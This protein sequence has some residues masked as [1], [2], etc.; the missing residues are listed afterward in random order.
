[1]KKQNSELTKA[2]L[3]EWG[4]YSIEWDEEQKTWVIDRF[5][6]KNKSRSK[7]HTNIK[8]CKAVCKHKYTKDKYYP[9][10]TFSYMNSIKSIPLA[11]LIYA[12][13]VEDIPAGYVIDHIDNDPFNN[14]INSK[15][16]NDPKN[17]LQMLTIEENLAKRYI[18]NPDAGHNQWS[19]M[20]DFDKA[21]DLFQRRSR[22]RLKEIKKSLE[23]R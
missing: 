15:D 3:L 20:D 13:F 23:D 9:I 19:F 17:N 12:W 22:K 5:W 8:I 4:I 2:M 16:I 14:Y 1:M 7:R 10:V 18:D 6:Y 21:S 11:R